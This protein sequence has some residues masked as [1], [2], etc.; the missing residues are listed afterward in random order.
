MKGSTSSLQ[1]WAKSSVARARGSLPLLGRRGEKLCFI[2]IPKTGGASVHEYLLSKFDRSTYMPAHLEPMIDLYRDRLKRE[3]Y[4]YVHGHFRLDTIAQCYTGKFFTIARNPIERVVS[5]Y[6]FMGS[7]NDQ[8]LGGLRRMCEPSFEMSTPGV[9]AFSQA[10]LEMHETLATG[11]DFNQFVRLPT[12]RFPG[13]QSWH[14]YFSFLPDSDVQS[15]ADQFTLIG[16]T[17]ELLPS[18]RA[19]SRIMG[20]TEPTA[21]PFVNETPIKK[22]KVTDITRTDI[23]IIRSRT[24]FEHALYDEARRRFDSFVTPKLL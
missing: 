19:L 4:R 22:I 14:N 23:E 18:M 1:S 12:D 3:E 10:M 2:H 21:I 16:L 6:N 15:Y 17:S 11:I 8:L 5:L 20:W 9:I 13:L 7:M 24:Q